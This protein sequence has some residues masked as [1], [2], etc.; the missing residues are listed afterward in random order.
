MSTATFPALKKV[1]T[2]TVDF[3]DGNGQKFEKF[4]GKKTEKPANAVQCVVDGVLA[5][6]VPVSNPL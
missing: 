5:W 1:K 4:K 2:V 6:Y 3:V